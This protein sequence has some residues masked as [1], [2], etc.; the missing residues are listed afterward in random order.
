MIEFCLSV[1]LEVDCKTK[2]ILSKGFKLCGLW[3]NR[4]YFFIQILPN[5]AVKTN[6]IGVIKLILLL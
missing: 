5:K 1:F 2:I 6:Y 3:L 4:D